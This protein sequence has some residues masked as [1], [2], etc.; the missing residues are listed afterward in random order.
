MTDRDFKIA[1]IDDLCDLINDAE[2]EAGRIKEFYEERGEII[3]KQE[4]DLAK[5]REMA[6][7]AK[8][9]IEAHRNSDTV[10]RIAALEG[11]LDEANRELSQARIASNTLAAAR[12]EIEH[13]K[14]SNATKE[15]RIQ[16]LLELT[17]NINE[18]VI[19]SKLKEAAETV[20]A[21][22]D[23]NLQLLEQSKVLIEKTQT[24]QQQ[25]NNL[26]RDRRDLFTRV[27]ELRDIRHELQDKVLAADAKIAQLEATPKPDATPNIEVS[28][29]NRL[30]QTQAL[31]LA[32]LQKKNLQLTYSEA[33]L[34]AEVDALTFMAKNS[35][36]LGLINGDGEE[37]EG[38]GYI[39]MPV[40]VGDF[41]KGPSVAPFAPATPIITGVPRLATIRT[42]EGRE[43][44][45][46]MTMD[47][48]AKEEGEGEGEDS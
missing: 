12:K 29:L 15:E 47:F 3:G 11:K 5:A 33:D 43:I 27:Q 28:A 31:Q 45:G 25:N 24:L 23:K 18:G 17:K 35:A 34:A 44:Q 40:S 9:Q 37:V 22:E 20:K 6:A 32:E 21:A 26:Q 42:P 4:A 36:S 39:S 2:F 30:V 46:T 48:K 13:L 19:E 10:I 38:P 14:G 8:L 16:Q 1:S 41:V 7:E